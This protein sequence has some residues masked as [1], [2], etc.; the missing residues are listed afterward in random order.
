MASIRSKSGR[1]FSRGHWGAGHSPRAVV[2]QVLKIE[3]AGNKLADSART[4]L[5]LAPLLA[6]LTD[7]R[8]L[9]TRINGRKSIAPSLSLS[10]SPSRHAVSVRFTAALTNDP[11]PDECAPPPVSQRALAP[12]DHGG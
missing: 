6:A 5:L 2:N 3:I 8:A 9:S 1:R 10:P 7:D 4:F 11:E 12:D